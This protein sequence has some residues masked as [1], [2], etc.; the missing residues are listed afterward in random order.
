MLQRARLQPRCSKVANAA[1]FQASSIVPQV[2][3][4][5]RDAPMQIVARKAIGLLLQEDGVLTRCLSHYRAGDTMSQAVMQAESLTRHYHVS[6]GLMKLPVT[7]KALADVSFELQQGRTLAV[8][9]RSTVVA[10]AHWRAN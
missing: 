3:W 4:R 5:R 8:V 1:L 10:K 6:Q 9:G 7:V 2:A